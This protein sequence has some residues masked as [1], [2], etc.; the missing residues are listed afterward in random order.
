MS[1]SKDTDPIEG[2]ILGPNETQGRSISSARRVST[3]T[4]VLAGY[5]AQL[6]GRAWKKAY[7]LQVEMEELQAS[8]GNAKANTALAKGRLDNIETEIRA[9]VSEMETKDATFRNEKERLDAEL[10]TI[11]GDYEAKQEED[12]LRKDKAALE[13]L[14]V[15]K[16]MERLKQGSDTTLADLEDALANLDI[17]IED[18]AAKLAALNAE[19]NEDVQLAMRKVEKLLAIKQGRRAEILTEIDALKR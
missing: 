12:A 10:A 8:F 1:N 6:E 4:N 15:Q 9:M 18:E 13:R 3:L 16:E 19:D 7:E 2:E 17:E 11:V 14:K 5:S